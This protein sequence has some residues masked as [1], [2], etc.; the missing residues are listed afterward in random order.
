MPLSQ[1]VIMSSFEV[2]VRSWRSATCVRLAAFFFVLFC[3][4]CR[5]PEH[6]HRPGVV[7]LYWLYSD[8]AIDGLVSGVQIARECWLILAPYLQRHILEPKGDHLL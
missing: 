8:A 2:G 7:S 1:T 4:P 6:P 5:H 3:L